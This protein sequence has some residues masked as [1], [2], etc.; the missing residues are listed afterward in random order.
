MRKLNF[1]N[2]SRFTR[3][4]RGTDVYSWCVFLNAPLGVI[5]GIRTVEYTLHPTFPNPVREITD[6]DH[7]FALQSEGWGTFS[8]EIRVFYNDGHEDELEYALKLKRDD[9]PKGPKLQDFESDKMKLVYSALFD[10]KWEWRKLSTIAKIASLAPDQA[11]TILE[12][13]ASGHFVRKA[14]FRSIDDQELWGATCKVG[15]LPT[16]TAS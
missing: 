5:N 1:S 3:Q 2:Y 4:S 8:I 10:P 9:W 6:A 16:P 12:R 14:Y 7:A 11:Q 13:L 15:K